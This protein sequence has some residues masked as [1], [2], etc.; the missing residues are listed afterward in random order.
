MMVTM[1]IG[2]LPKLTEM[3]ISDIRN[4]ELRQLAELRHREYFEKSN[5]TFD[6]DKKLTHAFSFSET[7]EGGE[8]WDD[9][10]NEKIKYLGDTH[11][12]E[13]LKL[14]NDDEIEFLTSLL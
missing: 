8:F 10:V 13:E 4:G 7:P 11:A 14:E 2:N 1:I 6:Y 12:A 9:V 5:A 3:N